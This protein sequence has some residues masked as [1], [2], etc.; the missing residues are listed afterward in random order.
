[1]FLTLRFLLGVAEAGF[2]PGIIYYLTTWYPARFRAR[3]ISALFLAVPVSNALASAISGAIL[4]MD[5]MLGFHGWQWVFMLEATPAIVLAFV[6][7]KQMTDRPSE[8]QWLT[9]E[10][11]HWLDG[12]L[13]AERTQVEQAGRLGL[14][15]SLT[16]P[17]V[18]ALSVIYMTSVAASYL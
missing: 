4:D 11:R 16:D 12:E 5:G 15:K 6:V 2:F 7:W 13:Q 10:E 9:D 3:V 1:S 14:L 8:A 17:R 18:I